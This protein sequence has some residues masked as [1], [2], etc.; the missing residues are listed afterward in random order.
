MNA[1]QSLAVAVS[2]LIKRMSAE[3]MLELMRYISWQEIEE[4]K[5]T[6]ETL[7]DHELMTQL[8]AGLKDEGRGD[9]I[10]VKL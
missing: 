1:E 6:Q 7:S 9:L 3:E 4:W 10:E 8:K 5:A 2:E